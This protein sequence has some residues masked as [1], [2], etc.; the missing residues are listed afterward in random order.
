M[1]AEKECLAVA[2]DIPVTIIRPPAVYGP[3]DKDIFE[4]FK[5][6]NGHL[7]PIAGFRKKI[8]SLIHV[9]DLVDGIIAAAEH[10]KGAGQ[11]Y[12][13][14]NEAIYDWSSIGRITKRILDKWMLKV[15]IPHLAV[16]TVAAASESIARL[17]GKAA[18]I[19][20]EKARDMV[21]SN[22]TCSVEKAK[23]ELG[24]NS[25][26]TIEAGIENTIRWYKV[27]GWLS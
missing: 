2:S 6:A 20:L 18:L 23:R 24:Y 4:F 5:S 15:R 9:Y 14:S 7:L 11:I 17:R 16:Y 1:E 26:L 3:R 27:N 12:F 21:Q 8:L 25:K 19:N 13:I 10:P 22:W